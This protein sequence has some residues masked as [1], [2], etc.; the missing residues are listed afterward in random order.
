MFRNFTA[1]SEPYHRGEGDAMR[2]YFQPNGINKWTGG[3]Y[4]VCW[5]PAGVT[6][7]SNGENGTYYHLMLSG[8]AGTFCTDIPTN[9]TRLKVF[10]SVCNNK[11]KSPKRVALAALFYYTI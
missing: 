7:G 4:Y 11:I 2:V 5:A 1:L 6:L 10:T 9:A 8:Q 3:D